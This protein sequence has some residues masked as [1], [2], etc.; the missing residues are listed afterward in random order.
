MTFRREAF[1][2]NRLYRHAEIEITFSLGR[3]DWLPSVC[4]PFAVR[5][6]RA[7]KQGH[8]ARTRDESDEWEFRSKQLLSPG[9]RR[10]FDRNFTQ[11]LGAACGTAR[12]DAEQMDSFQ[13][14][15]VDIESRF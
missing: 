15:I 1:G 7:R 12:V 9:M 5:I 11:K 14:Q 2:Q 8:V 4:C 10:A 13:L 6:C 3:P